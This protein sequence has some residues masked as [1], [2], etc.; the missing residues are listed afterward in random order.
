MPSREDPTMPEKALPVTL[1]PLKIKCT[2]TDCGNGLHCFRQTKKMKIANQAG[3]CRSCGVALIDWTRV[4]E[5]NIADAT[6]TARMLRFEMIRH[7]F[8]H[9]EIDDKAIKHARRKGRAGI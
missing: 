1:K 9:I 7:H 4:H 8:W 3:R 2:S 6:Y 5:R